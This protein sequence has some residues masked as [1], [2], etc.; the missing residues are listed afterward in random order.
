MALVTLIALLAASVAWW[1]RKLASQALAKFVFEQS[2]QS[3]DLDQGNLD[4]EQIRQALQKY[5]ATWSDTHQMQSLD[6]LAARIQLE[7]IPEALKT[8]SIISNDRQRSR[9][10]KQLLI[11]LGGANPL[12]AMACANAIDGKIVNDDGL[13]GSNLLFQLAVLDKWMNTDLPGAFGWVRQL[14]DTDSRQRALAKIIPALA[15]NNPTNTLALLSDLHTIPAESSYLPLFQRWA[16]NDPLQAIQLRQQLPGQDADDQIL[17]AILAAW[18]EKQP[19]GALNWLNAQP[20]SGYKNELLATCVGELAKTDVSKALALAESFPEGIWRTTL[21]AGLFNGWAA[22]DLEAATTAC[23]QLTDSTVKAKAWEYVLNQR[24]A[25]DPASAAKDVLALPPGDYRQSAIED[26]CRHWSDIDTPAALTWAQSLSAEPERI[27]AVKEVVAHWAGTDLQSA[28][29]FANQHPELSGDALTGITQASSKT[30]L[31]AITNWVD[32]LQDGSKKDTVLLALAGST[33]TSQPKVAA[34]SC[35]LLTTTLPTTNLVETIAASFAKDDVSNAVEWAC[36]L[37]DDPTRQAA[38]S[39]LSET[40]SQSYPRDMAIYAVA[41][42]AGDARTQYLTAACRQLAIADLP[43]TVEL[44]KSLPDAV[45]RQNLLAQAGA[46]CDLP[47]MNQAANYIA[48]MPPGDDQ[49]AVIKGLLSNWSPA[50]PETALNWLSAFPESNPQTKAMQSVV[51]A[52]AQSDPAEVAR[53]L[54]T[55]PTGDAREDMVAAFLEGAAQKYPEFAGQW[56]KSLTNE[57]QRQ[58]YQLLIARQWM[59]TNP[60]SASNWLSSLD[61][62]EEIKQLK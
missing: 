17:Q 14:P 29:Q 9:F 38:L 54:T 37:K 18:V 31:T 43:G 39:A 24:I 6:E 48:A 45:L 46:S 41:L 49:K 26:L 50:D 35:N 53:W 2:R 36:S 8:S 60:S 15:V 20:D 47:H 23:Q 61:L 57:V 3:S 42:P 56:T 22:K 13:A 59:K 19:D 5:N 30:N 21:I 62:P 4:Q 32:N 34:Q 55:L 7:D 44:L 16:T 10:Q 28:I 40:W 27:S 52:W 12:S 1:Q 33:A 58:Q 25:K 11:R 51:K